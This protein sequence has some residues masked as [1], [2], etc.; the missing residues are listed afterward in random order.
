MGYIYDYMK[1]LLVLIIFFSFE[2][3]ADEPPCWCNFV[4]KS[5]NNKYYAQITLDKKESIQNS[6][7]NKWIIT[8]YKVKI[9]DTIK[10]WETEYKYD[11]YV[12]GVLS[13]DGNVFAYVNFWYYN[14]Q[15]VVSIYKKGKLAKQIKGYEF[16]IIE[17]K[18]RKTVS[19]RLWLNSE[20][21]HYG[22]IKDTSQVILFINTIDN[23]THSINCNKI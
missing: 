4:I 6:I 18:M 16:N 5:P 14:N 15:S 22:F 2:V 13:N 10:H 9:K 12:G 17:N 11:G 7:K 3:V 23:K 8:V 1:T 21:E 19:H 20:K